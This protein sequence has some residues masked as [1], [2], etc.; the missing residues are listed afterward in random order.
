MAKTTLKYIIDQMHQHNYKYVSVKDGREPVLILNDPE[1]SID[2][3]IDGLKQFFRNVKGDFEVTITDFSGLEKAP[4]TS[5]RHKYTY[6]VDNYTTE[7]RQPQQP[8]NGISEP[9]MFQ[10]LLNEQQQRFNDRLEHIKEVHRLESKI[11]N[12]DG[13]ISPTVERVLNGIIQNWD[14][15]AGSPAPAYITGS[16]PN[17]VSEKEVKKSTDEQKVVKAVNTLLEHD[18]DFINHIQKLA[19]LVVDTPEVYAIAVEQLHNIT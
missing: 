17:P 6:S 9:S 16:G 1:Q 13:L 11:N 4:G 2:Q 12:S 19:K 7:V 5:T 14:K 10:L 3:N 8:M 15:I 18:P